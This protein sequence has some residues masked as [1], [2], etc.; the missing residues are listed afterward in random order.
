MKESVLHFRLSNCLQTILELEGDLERLQLGHVL[1]SE[2]S[3][4]RDFMDRIEMVEIDEN[5]VRRIEAATAN[6]L[7]ELQG[8]LGLSREGEGS[9]R[10]VQ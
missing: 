10:L 9:H 3:Q 4:L 6:F 8:P 5:D 2:F 1:L 7:E